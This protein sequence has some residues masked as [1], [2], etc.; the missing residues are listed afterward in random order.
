MLAR[1]MSGTPLSAIEIEMQL[2][3]GFKP[4]GGG[5]FRK[6]EIYASTPNIP[7]EELLRPFI[8]EVQFRTFATRIE[9]LLRN[10]EANQML[11]GN[12]EHKKRFEDIC[13]SCLLPKLEESN[14]YAAAIFML[15]ADAFVW[16]KAKNCVNNQ[17]IYFEN[18]RIHGVDLDGYAILRMSKELYSGKTYITVSELSDPELIN[19]K[20]LRLIINAF[21]VRR[22]GINVL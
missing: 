19:D 12:A 2:I 18:I 10:H 8:K 1:F 14:G 11:F 21:L 4:R 3:P 17:C 6:H 16:G 15:S 20:V 7:Y 13:K 9:K 22:Y 5:T